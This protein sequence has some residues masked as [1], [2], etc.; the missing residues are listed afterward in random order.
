MT[1]EAVNIVDTLLE[2]EP[3]EYG[4]EQLKIVFYQ[5]LIHELQHHYNNNG[6][7][8]RFCE[9]KHF[10]PFEFKGSIENIPPVSVS[11]FKQLGEKLNSVP[12]EDLKLT[13][14]SSATSGVPS[15]VLLDKITSRR[16]SKA[17]IKVMQDF[18]GKERKPFIV[19]DIIPKPENIKLLG[20]R[21]AAIG[22]YLNFASSSL[23]VLENSKEGFQFDAER[24]RIYLEKTNKDK[25]IILFGFTYILFS[26]ILK[27]CKES[28]LQ[29][30]LPPQSKVIHIGGWKKLENEEVSKEDFNSLAS[31]ILGIS[32][33]DVIDVYGFTEQM[34]LNY[35][36]CPCGCKHT[37]AYSK[38][39][40][41]DPGSGIALEPG[42]TGVLS[43]LSPIPH[44]YPGNIVQTDDVGCIE[45]APC[46]YGR[47]GTRFK[48]LGRLKKAEI[49]G[50]GDILAT[51]VYEHNLNPEQIPKS[52]SMEIVFHQGKS[53]ASTNDIDSLKTIIGNLNASKDWL[54]AQPI[55]A[56]IGLIS[57]VSKEWLY[58]DSDLGSLKNVGLGFLANWCSA[59]HLHRV[60]TFGLRGNS[61]Y[62]EN[63]LPMMESKKQYL[64]ANSRGL[65]CHWLAGNVQILGMFALIQS[66]LTKNVNLLKISSRDD[67]AFFKLINSFKGHTYV[68][69]G[70]FQISGNDLLDTISIIYFPHENVELGRLMSINA[71]VRIAWGGAQ[72]VQSVAS[73]PKSYETEDVIFGPKI[74][75]SVIAKES[76]ADERMAKKL[77]RK[78]AVDISIFDQTGCASPHNLYI[79]ENGEISPEA[80][81]E[82][83]N[84]ALKKVSFQIV[85]GH[86]STEELAAVHSIRGLYDFKGRVWGS[87]DLVWTILY[88][89]DHE[90]NDPIYSR[91]IVV[92]PVIHINDTLDFVNSNIQTIGIA[93]EGEKALTYA[94]EATKRGV[95]RCPAIG[96]M[97]N[98]ES[99]WDGIILMDR[100][101]RWN[102]LGGPLV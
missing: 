77:A 5:A 69:P 45:S 68:T 60:A 1:S 43:F 13:L 94:N 97:L 52:A 100:L 71:N 61:G 95:S 50:C 19:A 55:E 96:K 90:L 84:S 7:Y 8:R 62:M 4:E 42:Q 66:I 16:Q 33:E 29:F 48:V 28:K 47:N 79:E 9:V 73:Y 91:V 56:L 32:K 82:I 54:N 63:F 34:G 6:H 58:P 99:P 15:T 98:F 64:R 2:M 92:H 70:G 11:V 44:S 65:V 81:C 86:A 78:V 12:K 20:A 38:V 87:P 3:Y 35:P 53:L 57:K 74:S 46:E 102:T 88:D 85:K 14:Q 83:L 27:Y 41:R 26:A 80:F 49:R 25:G 75:F 22:G 21:Y 31:E 23:F 51:K 59:E 40:V 72:A 36:D 37:P 101:V 67:G 93:A 76:L 18:I 17:M 39:I 30:K 24:F 10:N 89:K